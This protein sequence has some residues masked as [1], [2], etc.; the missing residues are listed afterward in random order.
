M[1]AAVP[2]GRD[3]REASG[4]RRK[5]ALGA[6]DVMDQRTSSSNDG[7]EPGIG[8]AV[9]AGGHLWRSATLGMAEVSFAPCSPQM[10]SE[11]ESCTRGLDERLARTAEGK[12]EEMIATD[13]PV[14]TLLR[15][16]VRE[17]LDAHVERQP[18]MESLFAG[19]TKEGREAVFNAI[20]TTTAARSA[21]LMT[22]SQV[23]TA[24]GTA[25]SY[26]N[27]REM[28]PEALS[29]RIISISKDETTLNDVSTIALP[30]ASK[31]RESYAN[32]EF[33][34]VV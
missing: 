6:A 20:K 28:L 9:P 4:R 29:R 34:K 8:R 13:G 1:P 33:D 32:N 18:K 27:I 14:A 24:I 17:E 22:K 5:R 19:I 2:R 25:V 16:M 31:K 15:C 23:V 12:I 10:L 3:A 7:E 26:K 30:A 21:D 11:W